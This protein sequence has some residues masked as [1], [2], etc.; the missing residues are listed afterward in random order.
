MWE[1]LVESVRP[2]VVAFVW[3]LLGMYGARIIGYSFASLLSGLISL[4][5][6]IENTKLGHY[7]KIDDY[8]FKHLITAVGAVQR[9]LVDAWKAASEN[10]KLTP[11]QIQEAKEVAWRTFWASLPADMKQQIQKM[12]KSEVKA[13]IL[14]RIPTAV[15][16]FR[17]IWGTVKEGEASDPQ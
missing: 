5:E 7:S 11:V 1:S 8:I 3:T 15:D 14:A 12:A 17:G 16:A 2:V 9:D 4:Q 10:G 6:R 13:F